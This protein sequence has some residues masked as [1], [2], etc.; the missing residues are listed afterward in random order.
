MNAILESSNADQET[1]YA[2]GQLR[3][4]Y[5]IRRVLHAT[6]AP[7]KDRL[8]SVFHVKRKGYLNDHKSSV[9]HLDPCRPASPAYDAEKTLIPSQDLTASDSHGTR[10]IGTGHCRR[11]WSLSATEPTA[12]DIPSI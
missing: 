6:K 12:S 3:L 2:A 11:R 1:W 8:Y 10:S 9:T 5:V 7:C 4:A